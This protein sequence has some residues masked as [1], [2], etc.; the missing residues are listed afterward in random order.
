MPQLEK[1]KLYTFFFYH[2]NGHYDWRNG[3]FR[4]L[5]YLWPELKDLRYDHFQGYTPKDVLHSIHQHNNDRYAKIT[6]KTVKYV[7]GW[8][9]GQPELFLNPFD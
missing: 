5:S 3:S 1:P 7:V 8:W 6:T 2:D 9:C 4:D